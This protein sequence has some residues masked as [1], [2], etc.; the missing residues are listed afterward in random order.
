MKTWAV[1]AGVGA[2]AGG[3]FGG[4]DYRAEIT[5][6]ANGV[7]AAQFVGAPVL[8]G[9]GDAA[10]ERV[11]AEAARFGGVWSVSVS[12][13]EAAWSVAAAIGE[14]PVEILPGVWMRRLE[15]GDSPR[16]EVRLDDPAAA[17]DPGAFAALSAR[18]GE[19]CIDLALATPDAPTP[20]GVRIA[21]AGICLDTGPM[22]GPRRFELAPPAA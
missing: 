11:A 10:A 22:E 17:R 20:P 5:M 18:L 12:G 8:A 21:G 14:T 13:G 6:G 7:A 16:Y 2:M 1:I 15:G 4:D 9:G 19:V 3:L